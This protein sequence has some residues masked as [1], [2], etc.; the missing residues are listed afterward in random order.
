MV[1]IAKTYCARIAAHRVNSIKEKK[2]TVVGSVAIAAMLLACR[3]CARPATNTLSECNP[4][5]DEKNIFVSIV[6]AK[7]PGVV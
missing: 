6:A 1:F 2:K 7:K 3:Y 5:V 4:A